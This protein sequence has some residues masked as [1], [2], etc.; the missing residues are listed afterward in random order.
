VTILQQQYAYSIIND[1]NFMNMIT[2]PP[3]EF[4]LNAASGRLGHLEVVPVMA[5][6]NL[7]S[8]EIRD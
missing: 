3:S 5:W 6:V 8:P 2:L 1:V 4:K 7:P